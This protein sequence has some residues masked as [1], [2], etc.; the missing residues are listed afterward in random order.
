MKTDLRPALKRIALVSSPR[1]L[2]FYFR[3]GHGSWMQEA[4]VF[5]IDI[6]NKDQKYSLETTPF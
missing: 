1:I 2:S 5:R 4:I 3:P 6:N